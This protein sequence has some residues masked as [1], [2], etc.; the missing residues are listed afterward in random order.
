MRI[1]SRNRILLVDIIQLIRRFPARADSL[2][3]YHLITQ[4]SESR[5]GNQCVGSAD[6]KPTAISRAMTAV[7]LTLMLVALWSL[8]HRYRGVVG[9]AELYAVQALAHIYPQLTHDLFLLNVSQDKY[10]VFSPMYAWC[11]GL[12]GL[13]NAAIVLI[14]LCKVWFFTAAWAA[15]RSLSNNWTAFLTTALLIVTVGDYGAHHIFHYSEDMLTA[16]SPAEALIMTALA[17]YFRNWRA[18]GLLVAIGALFLHP[19]VALPGALLLTC[20][21]LPLRTGVVGTSAG[22]VASL[23]IASMALVLPPIAHLFPVMDPDWLEIVR[24]RSQFLFLQLWTIDDWRLNARPFISLTI[25]A[26]A[27]PDP[28]IRKLCVAALVVGAAGLAVALIASLIGPVVI[29]LQGQAWRWVWVTGLVSVLVL[30]P[31]VLRVWHD[32]KCGPLCAILMI[33]AWTFP[34]VDDTACISLALLLW[35]MRDRITL[36]ATRFL[37]IAAVAASVVIVV[38]IV[39]SSWTILSSP[40]PESGREPVLVQ[41]ARNVLGVEGLLVVFIWSI[42]TWIRTSHSLLVLTTISVGFVATAGFVLPGTFKDFARE[43]TAAE[44]KEFSDW[45]N[46][47]PP[48]NNVFVIPAY[49]SAAFAW[50]TLERPSYL[51]VDQSSGAVFSR[52]TAIE[53]RR[54]SRVLLPIRDPDWRILSKLE[55]KKRSDK[56]DLGYFSRPLTKGRLISLCSDSQLNFVVAKENVGFDPIRHTHIGKWKDWNL[57]DC[58]QVNNLTPPA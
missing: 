39:A 53:V 22:V 57:Y 19:L 55:S 31:T 21:W 32:E 3:T 47:I 30:A 17:F 49:N 41:L 12:V 46:A 15:T 8:T 33:T 45:R 2:G 54:R 58:K 50:F 40:P 16:R 28:R 13:R 9:D 51:T 56:A 24:E 1:L 25:S 35:S 52:A 38:W 20:L 26:L 6:S 36:R 37:Q 18:T 4:T 43:G 29:L 27:L 34:A 5:L 11:I 23:G 48:D 44:I 42:A 10:T 7:A 14:V